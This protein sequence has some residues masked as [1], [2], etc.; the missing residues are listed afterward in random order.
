MHTRLTR[1]RQAEGH[2]QTARAPRGYWGASSPDIFRLSTWGGSRAIG[3]P[4]NR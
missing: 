1:A 3:A 4:Q 2:Q